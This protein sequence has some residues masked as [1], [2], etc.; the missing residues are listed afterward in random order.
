[1]LISA[2]GARSTPYLAAAVEQLRTAGEDIPDEYPAH[3][4]PLVWEHPDLLGRYTSDAASA[5]PPDR[6]RPVRGGL[7]EGGRENDGF[8]P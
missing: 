2:I 4:S 3:P 8:A 1:M 5:R 6:P 7:G